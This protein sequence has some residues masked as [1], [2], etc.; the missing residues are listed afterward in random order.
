MLAAQQRDVAVPR[1]EIL[2][3]APPRV[4][5]AVEGVAVALH[6]GLVAIV[7][8]GHAGQH[9]LKQRGEPQP[10]ERGFPLVGRHALCA[11]PRAAALARGF[12]AEHGQRALGIVRADVVHQ[13][14]EH[15]RRI[16]FDDR[17]DAVHHQR[18]VRTAEEAEDRVAER[19][20]HH[21]VELP[22]HQVA[23]AHAVGR[24]VRGVLPD[25][26]EH[27][28]VFVEA[29]YR[30]VQAVDKAVGQLIGHIEPPAGRARLEPAAD[31]AA[32]AVDVRVIGRVALAHV[33]QGDEIPP[34]FVVV[35]PAAERIPRVVGGLLRA[36]GAAV[37]VAAL[38]VEIDAVAA[39]VAEHAVEQN[40]DAARLRR[41]T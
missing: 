18:G 8:A 7:D 12:A 31:D 36:V 13:D 16:V 30:A 23:A 2:L 26:A 22:A 29:F 35:R 17:L 37:S 14:V 6:A 21:A 11:L 24:L 10:L 41:G 34:A 9:E 3:L 38:A 28:R 20:V 5:R 27:E 40:A 25:F 4:A 15:L 19:I 32:F 33:R 39:R 1:E